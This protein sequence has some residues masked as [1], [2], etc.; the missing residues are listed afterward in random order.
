MTF[1]FSVFSF[2]YFLL[3][4]KAFFPLLY[5]AT[6]QSMNFALLFV[7]LIQDYNTKDLNIIHS[8]QIFWICCV[9]NQLIYLI[10]HAEL[11]I[12]SIICLNNS[13]NSVS[14]FVDSR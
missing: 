2:V 11:F 6:I 12:Y 13:Y 5:P 8:T 9:F 1:L 3:T 4:S 14:Q 7:V 10:V